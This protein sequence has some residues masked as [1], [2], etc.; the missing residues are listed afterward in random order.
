MLFLVMRRKEEKMGQV[1][2]WC[3]SGKL[4]VFLSDFLVFLRQ[5]AR[6]TAEAEWVS[7]RVICLKRVGKAQNSHSR[8]SGSAWAREPR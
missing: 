5:E 7:G 4:G 2:I 6:F 3:G 1:Y 8:E